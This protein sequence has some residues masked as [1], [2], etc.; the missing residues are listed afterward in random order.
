MSLKYLKFE[1]EAAIQGLKSAEKSRL[2][3][4]SIL[5]SLSYGDNVTSGNNLSSGRLSVNSSVILFSGGQKK[6]QVQLAANDVL[7][8]SLQISIRRDELT[9]NVRTKWYQLN[10]ENS[11]VLAK[12]AEVEAL[13]G[14]YESIYEEWKLGGK[15]SL[16]TDQAYQNLLNAEV[17]LVSATVTVILAKYN[18]LSEIGTLEENLTMKI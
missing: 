7:S 3:N 8:R 5:G 6:A 11:S 10:T 12:K 2:P 1:E 9:Q 16:D 18:L 14:L 15:T 17:D 13:R 4:L